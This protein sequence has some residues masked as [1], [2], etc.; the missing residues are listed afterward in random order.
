MMG[1]MD[2]LKED[3]KKEKEKYQT[4]EQEKQAKKEVNKP[5][6]Q[7]KLAKMGNTAIKGIVFWFLI[8]V[9][10]VIAIAA[11]FLGAWVWDMIF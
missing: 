1:F 4:Q 10:A 3:Y 8:P 2:Q 11:V 7:E 9:F 6:E 5:S